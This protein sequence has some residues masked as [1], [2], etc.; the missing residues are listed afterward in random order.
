MMGQ[1]D[2]KVALGILDLKEPEVHQ[3]EEVPGVEGYF[4]LPLLSE[5]HSLSKVS[6]VFRVEVAG[7]E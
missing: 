4:F 3:E 1:M 7:L 2:K 6:I 5:I